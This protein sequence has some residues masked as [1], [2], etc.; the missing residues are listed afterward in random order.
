MATKDKEVALYEKKVN[1]LVTRAQ[2][3]EIKTADDMKEATEMLSQMN[4][5]GDAIEAEKQKVLKPLNQALKAE[6]ARWKP[7]E[8]MWE[9]GI[10]A[11]RRAMT[12]YQTEAARLA[13]EKEDKIAARVG[14]GKGKLKAET[15]MQQIS[16]IER[17]DSSIATTEGAVQFRTVKKFEVTDMTLLPIKY[18][19]ADEA[20][21]KDAMRAGTELPGV[22][23]Y[24]EQVPVNFR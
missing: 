6:R 15:A 5:I 16:E 14:E 18:H 8:T 2:S 19:I 24:E 9:T 3:F 4:R 12:V 23:Y 1:P 11:I 13:R 7:I 10:T 17:P 21:I 20:K 22:R